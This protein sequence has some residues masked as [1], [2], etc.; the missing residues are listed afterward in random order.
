MLFSVPAYLLIIIL[1]YATAFIDSNGD[2]VS[3]IR[4]NYSRVD[5]HISKQSMTN[6]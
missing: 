2:G 3:V 5:V 1:H 6:K 4:R